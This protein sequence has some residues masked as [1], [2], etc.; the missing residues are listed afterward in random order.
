MEY[1][2][3][4][5]IYGLIFNV[6]LLITVIFKKIK[7][8]PRTNAYISLVVSSMFFAIAE[9]IS[10]LYFIKTRDFNGY[11]IAWKTRN[12]CIVFYVYIF[13]VYF[14]LLIKGEKYDT[15]VK[16][17]FKTPL[18][19]VLFIFLSLLITMYIAFVPIEDMSPDELY[20]VRGIIA[21]VLVILAIC[22]AIAASFVAFKVRK[23]NKNVAR[24][25]VLTVLL[26]VTIMP[27]QIVFNY[28]SFVPFL[29]MFLMYGF[30]HNIENPDIELLN[31]VSVLKEK[32]DKS[33]N[34]KTD[35]LFNLSYDLVSP[36]NTIISL[37]QSLKTLTVDNKDEIYRDLKSIKYAG[38]TL[39]DSIDNILDM[40]ENSDNMNF[41]KEYSLYDLLKRIE[42]VAIS[43]IG[44]KSIQ[45]EMNIDD[46]ISSR[47]MGDVNKIQKILLNVVGNATKY[48]E[49]GKIKLFVSC[50]Q[51]KNMQILHFKISDTGSGIKDEE[52]SFIFSDSQET[53]GVGLA[54]T[55]KYVESMNGKISFDSIYTAGT[56]FYIDIPQVVVGDKLI[57][58]DKV[59]MNK[60]NKIEYI[61]C[62]QYKVLIVDDDEL[63]IKVT[64]RILE[65]YKFNITYVT[66]SLECID[67]IKQEEKYD[68][69]LLDHKMSELDGI[70]VMKI[71]RSL[72]NYD[73]PK[74]IAL[75]ANAI[76]GARDY[77][78]NSGFDDYLSKPIDIYE[79]DRIINKYFKK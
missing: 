9:I 56:T 20:Y 2:L 62:S 26:F 53:S 77:Y 31:E 6:I 22:T 4:F 30:Y 32:I 65:K 46:N 79:L 55:K 57:S 34:T 39:L 47:F 27:I 71:L 14:T 24:S 33:S 72:E 3:I 61:D 36:M 28:I 35:F 70:Q 25:L 40:S 1:S 74:I 18:F 23:T 58:E 48:T 50:T 29:T 5:T 60:S 54:L 10:I 49:I 41:N 16:N 64:M 7:K 69:L 68:I 19:L 63:D 43:R 21:V 67:R 73:I 66:S 78:I 38:S 75:T 76:V 51:D 17:I 59:N 44:A 8:T 45:F 12:A 37:S 42:T 15:L 11:S 52:K 13:I